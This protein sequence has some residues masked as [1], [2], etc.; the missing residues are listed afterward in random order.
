MDILQD[1]A[2][3]LKVIESLWRKYMCHLSHNAISDKD[4]TV[5]TFDVRSKFWDTTTSL[6]P[7][8]ICIYCY[9][10]LVL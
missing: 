9:S 2:R 1:I 5:T 3:N 10:K 6:T 8:H 4:L 7:P